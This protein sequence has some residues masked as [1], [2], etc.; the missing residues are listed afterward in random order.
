M[1]VGPNT[2]FLGYVKP[3]FSFI[4]LGLFP[5][6]ES[7]KNHTPFSSTNIF[8]LK[9]QVEDANIL[10]L[11]AFKHISIKYS[12]NFLKIANFRPIS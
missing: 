6:E 11:L 4:V 9:R 2:L 8:Y 1:L 7:F 12:F 3:Q 5:E 10:L